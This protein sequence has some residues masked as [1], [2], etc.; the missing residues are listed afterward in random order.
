MSTDDD[1]IGSNRLFVFKI[2]IIVDY[3][4]GKINYIIY[5]SFQI[6]YYLFL[7]IISHNSL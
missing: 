2:F 1:E 7:P 5:W 6:A 4:A 3:S